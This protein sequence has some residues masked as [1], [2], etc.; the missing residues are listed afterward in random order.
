M[1]LYELV[2][3]SRSLRFVLGRSSLISSFIILDAVVTCAI[4]RSLYRFIM[5]LIL[6]LVSVDTLFLF[7]R[8]VLSKAFRFLCIAFRVI[9]RFR[10]SF[11]IVIISLKRFFLE[12]LLI[13]SF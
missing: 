8:N 3:V 1:F 9:F 13:I 2:V 4:L 5:F 10:C 11:N 12:L 6:A 7:T